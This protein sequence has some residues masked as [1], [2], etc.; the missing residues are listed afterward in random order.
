MMTSNKFRPKARLTERFENLSGG[1]FAFYFY[2]VLYYLGS[3]FPESFSNIPIRIFDPRFRWRKYS[4]LGFRFYFTRLNFRE[5]YKIRLKFAKYSCDIDKMDYTA[6]NYL[7]LF[8]CF[9]SSFDIDVGIQEF[10]ELNLSDVSDFFVDNAFTGKLRV[11]DKMLIFG[12]S[13][14]LATLDFSGYDAVCITKPLDLEVLGLRADKV[15]LVLN[16]MWSIHKREEVLRWLKKY[17]S[18]V[19]FSPNKLGMRQE[20]NDH[21]DRIPGFFRGG[22]MG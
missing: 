3:Y 8:S 18:V 22:P 15:I 4:D 7:R 5:A 21:F 12:P 17:P 10:G 2:A 13:A 1:R 9:K 11:I 6:R 16:H 20:I 14:D 19:C